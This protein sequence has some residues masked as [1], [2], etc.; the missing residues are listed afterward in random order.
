MSH[1]WRIEFFAVHE[2]VHEMKRLISAGLMTTLVLLVSAATADVQKL[3]GKDNGKPPAFTVD[4]PWTMDW[5]ARSDFPLLASIDMRLHDGVTGEFIG[6]VVEIKGTGRGL[7]LFESA[8]TFQVVVIGTFVEWDI[9]IQEISEEQAASLKR[10]ADGRPS[11][12]DSAAQAS[13]R[14]PEGS[15]KS[16]RPQGDENLLLF[17]DHGIGWRVSFSPPC[18][19]LH[20]AT[21]ISFVTSVAGGLDQ[22]DSIMLDDGTRCYFDRVIP[23]V[24]R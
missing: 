12:L 2:Q 8:G 17:D 3:S 9:E 14:V 13:R 18:P 11:L 6:M 19:G 21:A 20:S 10:K 4:G 15:F 7:K 16:W 22:Y 5:S 24:A 1:V 23:T